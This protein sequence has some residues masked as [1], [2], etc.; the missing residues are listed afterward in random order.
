MQSYRDLRVWQEAMNLAE[1]CYR[2]TRIFPKEELYGMI[3]QIRRAAASIPANIAEGYGRRTRGEY[4]QFL[5]I[6]H[7][8]ILTP[9]TPLILAP[10]LLPGLEPP[11][12]CCETLKN[13]HLPQSALRQSPKHRLGNQ[14]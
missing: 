12:D 5:Y 3:A 9:D 13:R 2:G 4:I 6:A 1:A 11:V 14:G 7:T 8:P 10:P